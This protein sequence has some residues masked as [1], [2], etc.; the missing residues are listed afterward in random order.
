MTARCASIAQR[1][2]AWPTCCSCPLT[3]DVDDVPFRRRAGA[4]LSRLGTLWEGPVRAYLITTSILF[5]LIVVAHIARVFAESTAVAKDPWFVGLTLL[6]MAMCGWGL[7]L[8]R[9]RA[10]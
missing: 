4:V 2:M 8:L 9:R 1:S 6:A 10:A 5:A 7:Q 3:S